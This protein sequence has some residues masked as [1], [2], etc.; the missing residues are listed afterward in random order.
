MEHS[1]YAVAL[2]DITQHVSNDKG[3]VMLNNQ[4]FKCRFKGTVQKVTNVMEAL[5]LKTMTKMSIK[6]LC[7]KIIWRISGKIVL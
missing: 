2:P 7:K 4:L 3:N 1:A 5:S 6:A